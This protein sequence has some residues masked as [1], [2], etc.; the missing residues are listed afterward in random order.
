MMH[1]AGGQLA[2]I[3]PPLGDPSQLGLQQDQEDLPLVLGG[4]PAEAPAEGMGDP[5]LVG[6]AAMVHD[7]PRQGPRSLD[8]D[9]LIEGHQGLQRGMAGPDGLD[10]VLRRS[11]LPPSRRGA[12][13]PSASSARDRRSS[14]FRG[15]VGRP[16]RSRWGG[17]H[18]A[19]DRT[20][21]AGPA[22]ASRRPDQVE[23]AEAG[24]RERGVGGFRMIQTASPSAP[25][26][27]EDEG[28]SVV[29]RESPHHAP[30]SAILSS[31]AARR[32]SHR[33]I[34]TP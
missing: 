3:H 19:A 18:P 8:E 23:G 14:A 6:P 4:R 16:A 33:E 15:S 31:L 17:T 21:P 1:R 26:F 11:R 28:G 12:G 5:L 7:L 27:R 9:R 30:R 32:H 2:C 24:S 13:R 22:R 20:H 25:L 34:A 29:G 10:A